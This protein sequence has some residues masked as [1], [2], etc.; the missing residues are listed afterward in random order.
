MMRPTTVFYS[1]LLTLLFSVALWGCQKDAPAPAPSPL[2]GTKVVGEG[3]YPDPGVLPP[4]AGTIPLTQV[5]VIP[6]GQ[7]RGIQAP[8]GGSNFCWERFHEATSSWKQVGHEETLQVEGKEAGKYRYRLTMVE[9][10]QKKVQ[11]FTIWIQSPYI[12]E[13][14]DF[15]PAPAQFVNELPAATTYQ[16]AI[17]QLNEQLCHDARNSLVSLGGWGGYIVF[18][19]DHRIANSPNANDLMIWGNVLNPN[20]N[21]EAGIIWVA[22]DK[23]GNGKVDPEDTWIELA[24]SVHKD[25]T[26][27]G[28]PL[29]PSGDAKY[30]RRGYKVT[31]YKPEPEPDFADFKQQGSDYCRFTAYHPTHDNGD[32]SGWV[33]ANSYHRHSYWPAWLAD[34]KE[35]TFT[36]TRLPNN[37]RDEKAGKPG[38]RYYRQYPWQW[39]YVDNLANWYQEGQESEEHGFDLDNAID[40]AGN[41]VVL[42]SVDFI[43][44]QNGQ[45]C[46]CGWIGESST[47]IS[48]AWDMSM[49]DYKKQPVAPSK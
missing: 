30:Y 34:Q 6:L 47:E 44:V 19:F 14:L 32:S 8:A 36:G 18:K 45:L 20:P 23:N 13:I 26:W 12:Q 25:P 28:D 5:V 49:L 2:P 27:R 10:Q 40:E 21:C 3:E 33:Q 29:Y 7:S 43:K 31:Y 11:E 4:P 46:Y 42:D 35:L 24:G 22:Q 37:Y 16:D 15:C 1:V 17:K 38:N 9:R 39:G 48:T 41:P